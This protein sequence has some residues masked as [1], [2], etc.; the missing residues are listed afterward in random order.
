MFSRYSTNLIRH[1]TTIFKGEGLSNGR[2]LSNI[3]SEWENVLPPEKIPGP[4]PLPG[5]GTLYKYFPGGGFDQDRMSDTNMKKYKQ[6]GPIVKEHLGVKSVMVSL[7]N[8]KD[9][10]RVVQAEG[11]YPTRPFMEG[12][13]AVS[14]AMGRDAPQPG[15]AH[16]EKWRKQRS[17]LQKLLLRP[18]S[19]SQ[20]LPAQ[21]LVAH[22]LANI[23]ALKRDENG[24]VPDL[25]G[26]LEKYAFDAVGLV[27][28]NK[29]MGTLDDKTVE[30]SLGQ[31][32]IEAVNN[33][34]K[35]I[36]TVLGKWDLVK[37]GFFK[38]Q[39]QIFLKNHIVL[40]DV[41]ATLISD[42]RLLMAEGD[43]T[44]LATL[45]KEPE[46]SMEF[47]EDVIA[48]LLLGGIDSTKHTLGMILYNLASNQGVQQ[49]LYE[50]LDRE[51][52]NGLPITYD[53]I[54]TKLKYLRAVIK[55][56]NRFNPAAIASFGRILY[57]DIVLSGYRVPAGWIITA[58][59]GVMGRLPEYFQDPLDFKP[60]RWLR[61][62]RELQRKS[63]YANMPFGHGARS[64]IG[65]RIAMQEIYLVVIKI[66]QRFKIEYHHEKMG[67]KTTAFQSLDRPLK[68]KFIERTEMS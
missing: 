6:Y 63:G 55:E 47:A 58:N 31:K 60:E 9:I 56:S 34:F 8:I 67:Y 19:V 16:G 29:R 4:R 43:T 3:G 57:K 49:Q 46:V 24:E 51:L 27:C 61:E 62:T 64:C 53:I 2:H 40:Y 41:I 66:L 52:P 21:E 28:F 38:K 26:Y 36:P 18:Q 59:N 12:L 5:I 1:S 32:C 20:Y 44:L 37:L 42:F 23:I 15:A 22:D 14:E 30:G 65:Q 54:H 25:S 11:K 48:G 50:E 35:A 17:F 10:E 33:I 68:F 7:Y 13:A 39:W 45:L